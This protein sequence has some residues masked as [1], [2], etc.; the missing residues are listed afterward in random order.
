M[1]IYA[2][3]KLYQ[4]KISR[5]NSPRL[6]PKHCFDVS[7]NYVLP[8]VN[9]GFNPLAGKLLQLQINGGNYRKR[10]ANCNREALR[11]FY[12]AQ[13]SQQQYDYADYG[14]GSQQQQYGYADYGSGSQQPYGDA[15][16]GPRSQ[17]QQY[18]YADYGPGSQQ[19]YGD[20]DYGPR[21][22][23]QY[24]E[25]DYGP[26]LQQQQY[27]YADYGHV[28]QQHQ[29]GYADYGHHLPA[30]VLLSGKW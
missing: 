25:A 2:A 23:Q 10:R 29:S 3:A 6:K 26:G 24:G 14:P 11:Q 30:S 17:Q 21:S 7:K 16:Y 22:Q 27:G 12:P 4:K 18:G 19:P 28:L 20:A 5:S 8:S 1:L 9:I 15:D 13:P